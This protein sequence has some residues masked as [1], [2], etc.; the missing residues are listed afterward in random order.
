MVTF[1]LFR[2]QSEPK[3]ADRISETPITQ[4]QH[5]G[6]SPP[7]FVLGGITHVVIEIILLDNF[8]DLFVH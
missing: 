6:I 3:L 1:R 4:A 7:N 2:L 5:S 8:L